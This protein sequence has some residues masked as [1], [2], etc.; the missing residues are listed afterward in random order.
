MQYICLLSVSEGILVQVHYLRLSFSDHTAPELRCAVCCDTEANVL[1]YYG[2][3]GTY[4]YLQL[5]E[6]NIQIEQ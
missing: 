2:F 4:A 5:L 3:V 1:I 6:S